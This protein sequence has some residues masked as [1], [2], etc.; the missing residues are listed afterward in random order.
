MI[1]GATPKR[2]RGILLGGKGNISVTANVAPRDMS[3]L[4]AAAMRGDAAV[5]RE[6]VLDDDVECAGAAE[7]DDFL[8][9]EAGEFGACCCG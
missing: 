5:L 2:L 3:D 6:L 4:C 8:G 7:D 1:T 9:F